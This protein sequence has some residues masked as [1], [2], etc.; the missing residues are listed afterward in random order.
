[1]SP[2]HLRK[3]QRERRTAR[4]L[5]DRTKRAQRRQLAHDAL[6]AISQMDGADV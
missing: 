3:L 1:M 4:R 2:Q 5:S 6:Q